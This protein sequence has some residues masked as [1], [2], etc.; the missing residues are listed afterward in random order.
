MTFLT[1]E[2]FAMVINPQIFKDIIDYPEV[3]AGEEPTNEELA[4]LEEANTLL[5]KSELAAISEA[6][7][8]LAKRYMV[9]I[10]FSKVGSA[11]DHLLVIKVIDIALYNIHAI[12]NPKQIP[13]IRI[14]RYDNAIEWLRE[15]AAGN[16][17]PN[18]L[19]KP[20]DGSNNLI[21]FGSN[22]KRD[23]YI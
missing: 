11:R 23:H 9:D 3:P 8:Y 22:K 12:L 4:L 16:V 6:K 14:M 7:T 5:D 21:Q 18:G 20:E 15:V 19:T 13:E 2:D 17:S 1:I 10:D